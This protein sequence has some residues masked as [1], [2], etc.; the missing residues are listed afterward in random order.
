MEITRVNCDAAAGAPGYVAAE[1]P[2]WQDRN[3]GKTKRTE[4]ET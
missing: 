4:G 3:A 2:A 1:T